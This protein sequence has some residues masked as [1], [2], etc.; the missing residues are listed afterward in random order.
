MLKSVSKVEYGCVP[1]IPETW[2]LRWE[3]FNTGLD[4]NEFQ[5]SQNHIERQCLQINRY[6]KR[7]KECKKQ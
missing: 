4:N 7:K 6:M 5:I 1:V 2:K 3:E